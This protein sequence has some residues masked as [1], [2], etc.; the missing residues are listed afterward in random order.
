M[1]VTPTTLTDKATEI[2]KG[3]GREEILNLTRANRED[4]TKNLKKKWYNFEFI[5]Y[6]VTL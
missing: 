6:E 2:L 1:R 4:I 5:S 3:F